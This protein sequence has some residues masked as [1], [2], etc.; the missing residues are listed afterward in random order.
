VISAEVTILGIFEDKAQEDF[1]RGLLTRAASGLA[2][3]VGLTA[4]LTKGCRFDYLREHLE[5]AHGF[6][7]VMVGVDARQRRLDEKVRALA[8]G[9]HRAGL[10]ELPRP[11]LWS[12]ARPSIEEWMMA[13][14]EALPAALREILGSSLLP[15]VRPGRASAESTA[16]QRLRD[17]TRRLVGSSLLRGGLEYAE[18]VA[19]RTDASRVGAARN[20]DLKELLERRLPEFLAECAGIG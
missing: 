7:G 20:P 1:H 13:D 8:A 12:A 2:M 10:S 9:V 6:R 16:K 11:L 4:R 14:A 17:W 5:N 18:E 3:E 19:R 15:A